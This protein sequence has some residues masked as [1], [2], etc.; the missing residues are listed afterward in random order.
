MSNDIATIKSANLPA[1]MLEAFKEDYADDLSGGVQGGFPVI[2]FKG[3]VWAVKAKG[4]VHK[5]MHNGDPVPSMRVVMLRSNPQLSKVYYINA[6]TEGDDA[7]PDCSSNNGV[8]PDPDSPNKQHGDCASCPHNVWGSRTTEAGT[9]AK[10]CSDS[11]RLAVVPASNIR[12][13]ALGGAMLL[14]IPPASLGNLVSYGDQLK[15]ANVPYFAVAT[16]LSFDVDCAYPKIKFE[17]DADITA[18]LDTNDATAIM[19]MRESGE[20]ARILVETEVTAAPDAPRQQGHVDEVADEVEPE[21]FRAD[22][23]PVA[24]VKPKPKAK[25][26][27]KPKAKVTAA[28]EPAEEVQHTAA[29]EDIDTGSDIDSLVNGLLG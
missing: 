13:E 11:R 9:K 5:L 22:P 2:G 19:E 23:E 7:A 28:P 10:A 17:Y 12:N 29:V 1:A 4:E 18:K 26:K 21:P 16:K 3:K 20:V 8:T 24:E 15:A 14:R 27:A 25:A 6:Y